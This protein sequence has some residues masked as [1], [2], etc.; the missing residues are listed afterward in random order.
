MKRSTFFLL[1]LFAALCL[2]GQLETAH[3]TISWT[4]HVEPANPTTWTASTDGYI[5]RSAN[6]TLTVDGDSDLLSQNGFLAYVTGVT[7]QVTVTGAGST[8]TNGA[9]SPFSAT[10]RSTRHSS[11]LK[12]LEAR[13]PLVAP[14]LIP[15]QGATRNAFLKSTH[16]KPSD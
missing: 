10:C 8:W 9:R 15:L 1:V 4:G 11:E 3:A 16:P 2:F 6:G 13:L 14:G 5:G 7:G 12:C